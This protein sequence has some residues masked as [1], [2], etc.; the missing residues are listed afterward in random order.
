MKFSLLPALIL[1]IIFS[2]GPTKE[3]DGT[4]VQISDIELY[5]LSGNAIDTEQYKGKRIFLNFWATW[6]GPCIQEMPSIVSAR[7]ALAN[8]SVEF[9]LASDEEMERIIKFT[10]RKGINLPF[11]Q[12]RNMD[13]FNIN[14]LPTTFIF[15]Q[16]GNLEYTEMGAR[17]W[18]KEE[19]INL[20]TGNQN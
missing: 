20:I 15:D 6:C 18:S 19:A 8:Q 3:K 16:N 13:T 1:S 14:A 9:L 17:D 10:E 2:C 11:A 4:T 7:E 12:V 5:D